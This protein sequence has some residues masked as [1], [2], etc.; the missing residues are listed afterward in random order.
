MMKC[1]ACKNPFTKKE[2]VV[3]RPGKFCRSCYDTYIKDATPALTQKGN[4]KPVATGVP[5]KVLRE[6]E[7][8]F[9][10]NYDIG[11]SVPK[12]CEKCGIRGKKC[13]RVYSINVVLLKSEH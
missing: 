13:R 12:L 1:D 7:S 10:R 6:N 11:M 2:L 3:K 4:R 9:I 8:R 5:L